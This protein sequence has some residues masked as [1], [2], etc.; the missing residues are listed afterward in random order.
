L[1][2]FYQFGNN[3]PQDIQNNRPH[4]DKL[5]V[6]A[7]EREFLP[8]ALEI[9]A[10]P[11][12]PTGRVLVWTLTSLFTIAV[13]WAFIGQI[14][15]VAVA[16]GKIIP[17]GH[18]KKIQPLDRG[19][20]K[21]IWV[22]EGQEIDKHSPLITLDQTITSANLQRVE[23]EVLVNRLK[24]MRQ[25]L[26]ER[27]LKQQIEISDLTATAIF[28]APES[29]AKNEILFHIGLLEQRWYEYSAQL[30]VM[31]SLLTQQITE[32]K[33][34]LEIIKKLRT[35]L[36]L[37]K[38]RVNAVKSLLKNKLAPEFQYLELEQSRIE[39]V[40]NLAIEELNQKKLEAAIVETRQK[41]NAF[42]ART[43]AENLAS[44]I[45]TRQLI[46]TL[47]EELKKAQELN[48]IQILRSPIKGIVQELSIHTING[49]VTP[50]QQLMLIVPSE[51]DLLIEAFI[52]N[53]NIGFVRENDDAEV[54]IHTFPF[55]K[56]GIINAK[57]VH[58]SNDAIQDENK[59]LIFSTKLRLE[60]TQ[61]SVG[62]K[63]IK[64]IPGMAVTAEIKTG[65]RRL[66]EYFL[67]PLLRYKQE[68]IRER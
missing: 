11:P 62:S 33:T 51:E 68:S 47:Q 15:I 37:I 60:K 30:A 43:A 17:Y 53:K 18:V 34:S 20:V 57:I 24:L 44:I 45:E 50:A 35:I 2:P 29:T 6:S 56:Y 49:I 63:M 31:N 1:K 12:S 41:T 25:Q 64:L 32:K 48:T 19:V 38:R 22:H 66:I 40:Q 65:K 27:I 8:A 52:E 67:A 21:K 39:M 46:V 3:K 26:F 14:D 5:T 10:S 54:K 16:E 36:P 28:E 9:Q 23:N 13:I 61:L 55:T 59:G 4:T 7:C 42:T 58:I